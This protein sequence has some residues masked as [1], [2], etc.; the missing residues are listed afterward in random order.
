MYTNG[1]PSGP[2]AEYMKWI[3]SPEAQEIVAEL[4]FVPI[5]SP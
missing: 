3:F 4:G 1:E 5:I 2:L